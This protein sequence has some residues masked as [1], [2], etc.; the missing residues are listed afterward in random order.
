MWELLEKRKEEVGVPVSTT[1][2]MAIK[3]FLA[4]VEG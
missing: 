3:K 2:Q 1:V 4:E